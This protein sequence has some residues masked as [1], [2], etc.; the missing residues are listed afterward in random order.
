M[1]REQKRRYN[2]VLAWIGFVAVFLGAP[3]LLAT[4]AWYGSHVSAYADRASAF[5]QQTE[6]NQR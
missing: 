6:N 1:N 4:L 5:Y 2:Q 3:I